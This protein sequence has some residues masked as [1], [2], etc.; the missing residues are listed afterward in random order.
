MT[1]PRTRSIAPCLFE[2]ETLDVLE[3]QVNVRQ[4]AAPP[5][6]SQSLLHP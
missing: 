6:I 3:V 4:F 5:G 2:R 1:L